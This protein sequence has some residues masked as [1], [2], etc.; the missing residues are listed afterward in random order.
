MASC[1]HFRTHCPFPRTQTRSS[2]Q[3]SIHSVS[4]A[5]WNRRENSHWPGISIEDEFQCMRCSAWRPLWYFHYNMFFKPHSD[6][7]MESIASQVGA[8][9]ECQDCSARNSNCRRCS[10]RHSHG[11]E[12]VSARRGGKF[13]CFTC[14][15]EKQWDQYQWLHNFEGPDALEDYILYS[16]HRQ[17]C[18][19]C[20]FVHLLV[21]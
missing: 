18:N 19:A 17:C 10:S 8:T 7:D 12:W 9:W 2:G 11:G 21:W 14:L 1:S 16:G 4:H 3:R 6:M 20:A 13:K 5:M 15:K